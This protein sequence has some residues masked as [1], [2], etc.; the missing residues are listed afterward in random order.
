MVIKMAKIHE[1]DK[2]EMEIEIRPT[3]KWVVKSTSIVMDAFVLVFLLWFGVTHS[4]F[5]W[6]GSWWYSLL[7]LMYGLFAGYMGNW[8]DKED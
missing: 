2:M 3:H 7:T 4:L 5:N 6:N 1:S 8:K